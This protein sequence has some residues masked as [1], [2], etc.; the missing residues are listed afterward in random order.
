MC[1]AM[2]IPLSATESDEP[3]ISLAKN[4]I[5]RNLKDEDSAKFRDVYVNQLY[6][7]ENGKRVHRGN[8]ICGE[9]NAKNSFGGYTGYQYFQVVTY[10]GKST[11]DISIGAGHDSIPCYKD[12]KLNSPAVQAAMDK[13]QREQHAR[14]IETREQKAR[15]EKEEEQKFAAARRQQYEDDAGKRA[16]ADALRAQQRLL[17]QYADRIKLK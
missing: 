6:H 1:A 15:E 5:R 17:N 10:V 8:T 2:L 16:E 13:K 4:A 12:V 11:V 7:I 14:E 3:L 9:V